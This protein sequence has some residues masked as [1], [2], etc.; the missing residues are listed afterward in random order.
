MDFL[1]NL[2]PAVP[3]L[4]LDPSSQYQNVTLLQNTFIGAF[5][6][7]FL[8]NL[9]ARTVK[10]I[11]GQSVMQSHLIQHKIKDHLFFLNYFLPIL[12][13]IYFRRVQT[14]EIQT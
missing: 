5:L 14:R 3:S 8:A 4:E 12:T 2:V 6:G 1:S 7:T 13:L 10:M 9:G 11:L